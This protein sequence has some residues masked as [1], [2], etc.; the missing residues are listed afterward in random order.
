M[1]LTLLFSFN[2]G[3]LSTVNAHRRRMWGLSCLLSW[4][5]ALAQDSKIASVSQTCSEQHLPICCSR[6]QPPVNNLSLIRMLSKCGFSN[7][8]LFYLVAGWIPVALFR[9]TSRSLTVTGSRCC[10]FSSGV[11]YL[12]QQNWTRIETNRFSSCTR[13]LFCG[14]S[15]PT[16]QGLQ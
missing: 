11:V 14:P 6:I 3:V 15:N 7:W 13:L 1:S 8:W 9:E 4:W 2:L 10:N 5:N 16:G 12:R